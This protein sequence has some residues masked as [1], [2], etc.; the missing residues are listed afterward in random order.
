MD[1]ISARV[2]VALLALSALCVALAPL[3]VPDT[4][5]AVEHSVSESGGQGVP[6]AWVARSG[7]V[8]LGL[9]VLLEAS[10]SARAWGPW[11]RGAHGIYGV[12]MIAV[13]IVSHRAWYPAS[14]DAVEDSLHSVAATAVGFAFVVGVI[15]VGV[16][17]GPGAGPVRVLDTV[18][19]VA[20]VLL[21]LVMIT[22]PSVEGAAQRT[23]FA[24]G[25]TWYA[26]EAV[27][28]AREVPRAG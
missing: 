25:Y 23:L 1:R 6:G 26:V 21:P 10:R 7:F 28:L 16:R 15:S 14:W 9:A 18:A 20:S 27:L 19:V 8:L 17:R 24:V 22:W 2:V 11:G 5:D 13:A 12:G 3:A 4:Y